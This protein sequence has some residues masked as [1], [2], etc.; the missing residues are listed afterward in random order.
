MHGKID[1]ASYFQ[2]FVALFLASKNCMKSDSFFFNSFFFH[3]RKDSNGI[4]FDSE[5]FHVSVPGLTS[6]REHLVGITQVGMCQ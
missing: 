6:Q 5:I 4:T 1:M 3:L 2:L